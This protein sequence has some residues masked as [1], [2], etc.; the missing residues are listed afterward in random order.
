[1]VHLYLDLRDGI[2]QQTKGLT[3]MGLANELQ[4]LLD[5]L[6]DDDLVVLCLNHFKPVY[7]KFKK[8]TS[9]ARKIGLLINYCATSNQLGKLDDLLMVAAVEKAI[10]VLAG[11]EFGNRK[12]AAHY[13]AHK[14]AATALDSDGLAQWVYNRDYDGSETVASMQ[15]ELNEAESK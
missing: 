8:G 15:V 2:N 9:K 10:Q 5:A 3:K 4:R 1:M 13:V 14:L 12:D 7:S 11:L 6:P